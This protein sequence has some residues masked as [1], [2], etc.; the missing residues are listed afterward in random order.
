[1][2]GWDCL[3]MW[4]PANKVY[5]EDARDVLN[6]V[7]QVGACSTKN[8]NMLKDALHDAANNNNAHRVLARDLIISQEVANEFYNMEPEIMLDEVHKNQQINDILAVLGMVGVGVLS[9]FVGR[10]VG[11]A[12]A[13]K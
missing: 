8:Y 5:F 1:M 13:I 2:K 10:V 4:T 6:Y 11:S 3:M 9:F 7:Q 12:S